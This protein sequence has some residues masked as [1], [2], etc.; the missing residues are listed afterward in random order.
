MGAWRRQ[1]VIDQFN[2]KL[3]NGLM[4]NGYSAEFA[5][6]LFKQIRGF[7]EYG[8]PESH[9][10]SFALLVYASAW[11]KCYYPAVFAAALLNSQPMGFYAPAQLVANARQH[12]VEVLPVDVNYSDWDCTL[13]PQCVAAS[14]R[15]AS[16]SITLES[17]SRRDATTLA[18]VSFAFWSPDMKLRALIVFGCGIVA[19]SAVLWAAEPGTTD[20]PAVARTR[21]Q[22]KMLDDLY[23]TTVVFITE[24]FVKDEKDA[25]AG[26][27]AN[28]LFDAMRKKNHH[29]VRLLDATGNP[30]DDANVAKDDFEKYAIQVI[31]SG[32]ESYVERVET[33]DGTRYLRAATAVPVVLEKCT[34]CHPHFKDAKPGQAIGALAYKLRIE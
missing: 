6:R 20:D 25:S 19:V 11:I 24:T 23:K 1:G 3:V 21:K 14:L 29:D 26:M 15:D 2:E 12:D 18:T 30:Y 33:T 9:A 28:A 22:I 13:E 17:A 32:K 4:A 5:E 8:F 27:A 31:K 7:G 34:I 16:P 10:A